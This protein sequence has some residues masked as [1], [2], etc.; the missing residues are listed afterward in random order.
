[1]PDEATRGACNVVVNDVALL[2]VDERPVSVSTMF[3]IFGMG[4]GPFIET[5]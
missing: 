4:N 2:L 3:E 5:R 1:M